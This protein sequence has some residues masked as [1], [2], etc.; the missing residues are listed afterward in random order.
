MLRIS[1]FDN[2][3]ELALY[4]RKIETSE[5]IELPDGLRIVMISSENYN[6]LMQGNTFEN[7]FE[8]WERAMAEDAELENNE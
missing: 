7:Y 5:G 1:G 3:R 2:L 6:I 4:R 8:F